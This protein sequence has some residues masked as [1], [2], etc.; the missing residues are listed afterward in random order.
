[1]P[2]VAEGSRPRGVPPLPRVS[3]Y[4][5]LH[6][7]TY[8]SRDGL[9]GIWQLGIE[10]ASSLAVE[11]GKFLYKLPYERAHIR[12]ERVDGVLHYEAARVGAAFSARYRGSGELFSADPGSLEE[13]LVERYCVYTENGGTLYRAEVQ[14]PPWQLQRAEASIDL[15]TLSP[16]SLADVEH[17]A[18]YSPRQD[19]V[20]W[21][22][23]K[24]PVD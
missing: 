22:L 21:S 15:D 10:A 4:P 14:H 12:C 9:P 5:E 1:V 18:L 19:A 7:R 13:F 11:A 24:L 20:V 3:S 2:F 17:H 6:V 16:M 23:D 8:V